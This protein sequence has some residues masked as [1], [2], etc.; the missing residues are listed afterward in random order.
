MNHRQFEALI[1]DADDRLSQLKVLYEQWFAGI[2]RLPPVRERDALEAVLRRLRTE[3]PA[4]TA[5]R[6]RFDQLNQRYLTYS[7]YWRRIT[8][9]IEE[10]TYRRDQLKVK[11]RR[12][13]S[14]HTSE[15]TTTPLLVLPEPADVDVEAA[16]AE[17]R[18]AAAAPQPNQAGAPAPHPLRR[19][20][21]APDL[22]APRPAPL[23]PAHK[24]PRPPPPSTPRAAAACRTQLS[25]A[26]V[27][28][29]YERYVE[30]RRQ[31]RESTDKLDVATLAQ[32]LR[33][34]LPKLAAKHAGKRIDF[35]VVLKNGK[36]ALK[37]VV[38]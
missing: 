25:D 23:P 27:H 22:A 11:R 20:Q 28:A 29:I 8:R 6:F 3:Q 24:A 36:V 34:A 21:A 38:R 12:E 35:T 19:P 18:I 37:P 32:N 5:T 17:A 7:M 15:P 14:P 16:L 31:N 13:Q 10:G 9:Q 26:D 2:E 30:A 33:S 4:N 1:A